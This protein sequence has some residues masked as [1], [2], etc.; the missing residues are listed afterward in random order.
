VI[1]MN[2]SHFQDPRVRHFVKGIADAFRRFD[3]SAETAIAN[4]ENRIAEIVHSSSHHDL[5]VGA[6]ISTSNHHNTIKQEIT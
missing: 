4:A 5:G 3:E 6:Q 2:T 1:E